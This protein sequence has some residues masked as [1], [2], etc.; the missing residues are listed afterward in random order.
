[1]D[2]VEEEAVYLRA[3][4]PE[5]LGYLAG[6]FTG[7]WVGPALEFKPC[8]VETV[9]MGAQRRVIEKVSLRGLGECFGVGETGEAENGEGQ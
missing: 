1:M 6:N 3:Q 8:D 7:F 9:G 2:G 5:G 4:G